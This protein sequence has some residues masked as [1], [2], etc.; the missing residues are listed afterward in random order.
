[1]ELLQDDVEPVHE[2]IHRVIKSIQLYCFIE[3]DEMQMVTE[4]VRAYDS[5]HHAK[6][7]GSIGWPERELCVHLLTSDCMILQLSLSSGT[8][9]TC[10]FAPHGKI[11]AI[12]KAYVCAFE[13]EACASQEAG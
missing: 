2:D 7:F 12:T 9:G 1:M 3:R 5:R 13:E 10:L 4:L 6:R 11:C 8:N